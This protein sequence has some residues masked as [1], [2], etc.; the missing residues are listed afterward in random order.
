MAEA[1]ITEIAIYPIKPTTEGL[2]GF[3]SFVFS[4]SLYIGSVAIHSSLSSPDGFRLVFPTKILPN[5]KQ[6]SCVHPIS[7]EVGEAIQAAVI[8]KFQVLT[9]KMNGEL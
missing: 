1:V 4:N 3:C 8:E 9:K 5:G 6:I 2:I 7:R